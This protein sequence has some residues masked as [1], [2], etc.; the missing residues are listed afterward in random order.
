MIIPDDVRKCV[1]FLG[2]R[3]ANGEMKFAGSA[4]FIGDGEGDR[5]N[6]VC[7]VSAKHVINGVR[8]KGLD[9]VFV[10][11]NRKD[12]SAEWRSTLLE[13]WVVHEDPAVDVCAI[14]HGIPEELDH[15]VLPR[16]ITA[17]AEKFSEH[18]IGLGDEVFIT[19]LFR[20]H[21]GSSRNIPIVRIGNLVAMKEEKVQT[22]A[23][24]ADAYLVEARSIGGISGSPVFVHLG[25]A[26]QIG[27]SMMISSGGPQFL[28]LGL[29]HGHYDVEEA[30]V[31]EIGEDASSG[32]STAKI[33]SGIA[34][35]IPI[36]KAFDL[37]D[38]LRPVAI[39]WAASLGAGVSDVVYQSSGLSQDPL[40]IRLA[41][42]GSPVVDG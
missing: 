38:R 12:G 5:A 42:D 16:A 10:R 19:G 32:L 23:G 36:E 14:R 4:F 29:V 22:S 9:Q 20:H 34:I 6:H 7:L 17:T 30:M 26:R 11:F 35:V 28:L 27:G 2:Y 31:D 1:V 3:L 39:R 18:E 40:R 13:N 21:T 24:M 37:L 25:S 8:S 33:N 41:S 15:L